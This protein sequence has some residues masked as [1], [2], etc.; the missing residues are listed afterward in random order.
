[1]KKT[2]LIDLF[3][4]SGG[5]SLGFSL[6][7]LM[8]F[9]PAL[10][11]DH[12]QWAIRSFKTNFPDAVA[13]K[14]TLTNNSRVGDAYAV[15]RQ[16][17]PR[18]HDVILLASPPCEPFSNGARAPKRV[19]D[20]RD[21][22]F[23]AV[24]QWTAAARPLAVVVENVP[25]MKGLYGGKLH[26]ELV[27]GL[28]S[29]AYRV[30]VA[31]LNGANHGVPQRR[32]RLIYVALRDDIGETPL[33]LPTATHA[34]DPGTTGLLP[35]VT[36]RD[37]IQ[38]LPSRSPGDGRNDFVSRLNPDEELER[39][40][41]YAAALRPTRG[42]R[43][44]HH[45]ARRMGATNL[46]R[47]RALRPGEAMQDLPERMRPK[48]GF[49]GSYGRLD[50]NLPAMTLTASFSNPGS[51]TFFHYRQDRLI[52]PR[53]GARLQGFPDWFRWHGY[54]DH[55]VEQIGDAVPPPLAHAIAHELAHRLIEAGAID[56][57]DAPSDRHCIFRHLK[58]PHAND[59]P[60]ELSERLVRATV[61]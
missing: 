48:M 17:I 26:L 56:A 38:D 32:V 9:E 34:S 12:N 7:R 43:V 55:V 4:G 44:E 20:E 45:L 5:T 15:Y 18:G 37:A 41:Y 14:L 57:S 27:A 39:L 3:S 46:R 59:T 11:I 40:G 42:T 13:L 49:P 53:E 30:S 6:C 25:Q 16:H 21:Y 54:Y 51:G 36:V 50:P 28:E 60:S 29:L 10:G 19:A 8:E 47:V 33:Q 24:L 35:Y 58:V 2:L 22:L 23:R 31:S 61:A 1:M 52:T